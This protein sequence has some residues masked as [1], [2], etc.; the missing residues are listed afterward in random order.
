MCARGRYVLRNTA[1]ASSRWLASCPNGKNEG[2]RRDG[3]HR[4]KEATG[5]WPDHQSSR[6]RASGV[7]S[8]ART[9]LKIRRHEKKKGRGKKKKEEE[10]KTEGEENKH[11]ENITAEQKTIRVQR[12][13]E[14]LF[15]SA[16]H[17]S[18]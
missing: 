6:R 4:D 9:V 7:Q 5:P 3:E 2:R 13:G 10:N 12:G 8:S 18:D 1:A 14:R 15:G 11:P 16:N 17:M